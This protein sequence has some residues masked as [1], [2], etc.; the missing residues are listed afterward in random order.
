MNLIFRVDASLQIGS[1]HVMRC[2]TLAAEFKNRGHACTFICRPHT[3]N[4]ISFIEEK[5]IP[6]IRLPELVKFPR[7]EEAD[8]SE[9]L[10][11]L[12]TDVK[13]DAY[14]T[15]QIILSLVQ[16]YDWLIVDHYG[17]DD[18]WENIIKPYVTKIL[19]IDDLANRKH[20]CDALLDQ[21]FGRKKI[22]YEPYLPKS[23]AQLLGPEYALL[24]PEFRRY[25]EQNKSHR[26]SPKLKHI[27]VTMGGMDKDNMTEVVLQALKFTALPED[28]R[29]TVV[30]GR[31]APWRENVKATAKTLKW[32]VFTIVDVSNMAQLMTEID[33]CIGA[34]GSTT[35]ERCC[36]GVPTIS[37]LLAE[38]Q[39]EILNNLTEF[40]AI[41]AVYN[42]SI[43]E[44]IKK[45]TEIIP[46]F[47]KEKNKLKNS[48]RKSLSITDG[49]GTIRVVNFLEGS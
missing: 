32:P 46:Y 27:L 5:G 25:R 23:C 43:R 31:N 49:R 38:N 33:L 48:I 40:G 15:Q 19:L 37:V 21:T 41:F 1:G 34:A 4:M 30:M 28:C 2:L 16:K 6:V 22:D 42:P 29:I 45:I 47:S 14:Q 11:W 18:E 13:I 35:W 20:S 26:S 3:G 12:G 17:V 7:T 24:R 8:T 10:E 9:Y 44:I 36:L 39:R